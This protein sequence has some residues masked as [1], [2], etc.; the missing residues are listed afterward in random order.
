MDLNMAWLNRFFVAEPYDIDVLS[1]PE[2]YILNKNGHI[3][4]LIKN[5]I[6]IGTFAIMINQ[7]NELELTKMA[8]DHTQQGNGYA[9]LMMQY[10]ITEATKIAQKLHFATL[11]LYSNTLLKPAINLY[12][13]FGFVKIP[14]DSSQYQRANIKMSKKLEL[15]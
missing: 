7:E 9:N 2:E 15:I 8:I 1:H 5:E 14:F 4:F 3:F 12:R 10:C 11:I 6:A 13:K